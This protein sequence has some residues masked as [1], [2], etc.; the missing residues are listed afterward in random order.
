MPRGRPKKQREVGPRLRWAIDEALNL[1][2]TKSGKDVAQH[3]ADD[4]EDRGIGPVVREFAHIFPKQVDMT[5]DQ[6]VTVET[7]E[8]SKEDM[9]LIR[10]LKESKDEHVTH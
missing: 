1:L 8:V 6:R 4:M 3:I 2:Q 5:I 10:A 9:Q 7:T